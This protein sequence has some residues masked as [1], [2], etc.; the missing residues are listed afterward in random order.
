LQRLTI[1]RKKAELEDMRYIRS[2][3][4][5]IKALCDRIPSPRSRARRKKKPQSRNTIALGGSGGRTEMVKFFLERWPDREWA[6]TANLDAPLHLAARVG[7]VYTVRL[8]VDRWPEGQKE[9][10]LDG[11]TP[12]HLAARSGG[13]MEVRFTMEGWPEVTMIRIGGDWQGHRRGGEKL[14]R[15]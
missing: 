13:R 11:D 12:V 15:P 8:L 3:F 10:N 6:M 4:T 2:S 1:A 14:L 7:N 5:K 9:K